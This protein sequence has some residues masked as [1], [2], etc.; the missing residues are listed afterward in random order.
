VQAPRILYRDGPHQPTG[1][2]TTKTNP[3]PL[4]SDL[5]ACIPLCTFAVFS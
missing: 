4:K 5:H 2:G 3:L 1:T